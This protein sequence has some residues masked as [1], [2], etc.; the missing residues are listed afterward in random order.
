[1]ASSNLGTKLSFGL[2]TLHLC[3]Y[4]VP[5]AVVVFVDVSNLQSVCN[6]LYQE[7]DADVR[8]V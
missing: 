6:P 2:S 4:K 8:C 5:D 7:V 1:M 3:D